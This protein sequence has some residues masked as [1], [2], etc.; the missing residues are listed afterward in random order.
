ME[1]I[2]GRENLL[3]ESGPFTHFGVQAL[4]GVGASYYGD[5]PSSMQLFRGSVQSVQAQA[6]VGEPA[7]LSSTAGGVNARSLSYIADYTVRAISD[8]V[9]FRVSRSLYQAARS[10]TLLE[11]SKNDSTSQRPSDLDNELEQG[12]QSP[13]REQDIND[14]VM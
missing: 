13:Y 4:M 9:Y 2:V 3:F 14:L 6:S 7:S 8:V 10:A 12:F 11:R 5:S 1:V